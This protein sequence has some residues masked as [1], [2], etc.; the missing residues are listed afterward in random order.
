MADRLERIWGKLPWRK[1][2]IS[3]TSPQNLDVSGTNLQPP[4]NA[5]NDD[6]EYLWKLAYNE[7]KKQD[8]ELVRNY[9]RKVLSLKC[10]V[11]SKHF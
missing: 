5:D 1:S 3:S 11:R 2:K 6:S 8:Q 4:I 7:L 9:G 10:I